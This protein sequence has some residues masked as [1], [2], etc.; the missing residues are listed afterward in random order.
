MRIEVSPYRFD[1]DP[2]WADGAAR[3]PFDI[4]A[5]GLPAI[6][7][8]GGAVASL[9]RH[10]SGPGEGEDE[11]VSFGLLDVETGDIS[12]YEELVDGG[13]GGTRKRF[14]CWRWY[15]D[16]KT[17]A[18]E[19]NETLANGWR[20][21][22]LLPVDIDPSL[23]PYGDE[24]AGDERPPA[25]RRPVELTIKQDQVVLRVPGVKVLARFEDDWPR[26]E[27]DE[28][29]E[30]MCWYHGPSPQEV[31]ADKE[32]G[33]AMVSVAYESGPCMCDSVLRREFFRLDAETLAE[34]ELR[35][36]PASSEG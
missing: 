32:T 4:H 17:K 30:G 36:Q 21:M 7:E 24:A 15:K 33:V 12:G 1:D 11:V 14:T 8:D 13:R 9:R 22:H 20:P 25:E 16:A 26:P 19:I 34:I 6:R 5:V 2:L 18:L 23:G 10:S 29:D 31:F 3:C 27:D 28:P 35:A